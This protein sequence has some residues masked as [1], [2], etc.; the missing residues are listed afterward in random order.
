MSN[1]KEGA[2]FELEPMEAVRFDSPG[3]VG[4]PECKLDSK[5]KSKYDELYEDDYD[6]IGV[7]VGLKNLAII[8]I[9]IALIGLGV[10]TLF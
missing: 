4:N 8:Y 10:Y 7:F 5:R 3:V 1:E 6:G 2:V 9:V